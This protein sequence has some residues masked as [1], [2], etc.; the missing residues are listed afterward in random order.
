MPTDSYGNVQIDVGLHLHLVETAVDQLDGIFDGAHVDFRSAGIG[1]GSACAGDRRS[2]FIHRASRPRATQHAAKR[3]Y[4]SWL[5]PPNRRQRLII[6]P[7]AAEALLTLHELF[8][9]RDLGCRIL[10]LQI[11]KL[12][13][14]VDHIQEIR[15]TAI[16]PLGR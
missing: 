15:Q 2:G 12:A 3:G 11:I 16:V 7:A 6:L 14:G 1:G 5:W 4:D 8:S 10:F 13:L 9:L